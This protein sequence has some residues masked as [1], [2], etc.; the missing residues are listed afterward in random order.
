MTETTSDLLL[1][2]VD[3]VPLGNPRRGKYALIT[4]Q[5][6][7]PSVVPMF[8]FLTERLVEPEATYVL[9]K[10]YSTIDGVTKTLE[11]RGIRVIPN[12]ERYTRGQYLTD[13]A[14][15]VNSLW[16]CFLRNNDPDSFE[17]ILIIDEGGYLAGSVPKPI[18][19]KAVAIEQTASGS[20]VDK[21]SKVPVIQVA[22][23]AAKR[24][25]ES[26]FIGRSIWQRFIEENQTY[27]CS[28]GVIGLGTIGREVAIQAL[29]SGFQ[30]SGYD[31]NDTWIYENKRYH[32]ESSAADL[33]RNS[34]VIFGC[35][36]VDCFAGITLP[37]IDDF[38]K[39]II[40]GSSGDIEF[41][42][43][44]GDAQ[45]TSLDRLL[46]DVVAD[47]RPD[48]KI[49]NGGF[50]Y[51]FNRQSELESIS[52]IMLTRSLIIAGVAQAAKTTIESAIRIPLD[53]EVQRS[54]VRNWMENGNDDLEENL[55]W[56]I[57]HSE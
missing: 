29:N 33:M 22:L 49:L 16:D 52:D 27:N 40:S 25:F 28:V 57:H 35:T 5:H 11:A 24:V 37:P 31:I 54:I 44:L 23:S 14:E 20:F 1:H 19:H 43:L 9:G 8:D 41:R 38:T 13:I 45:R 32:L 26:P 2:L 12:R 53:A 55:Q 47:L 56:W 34:D 15:D 46:D 30:V 21:Q 7:L 18:C 6:L 3:Q 10:P 48:W 42:A 39:T 36:G 17:R 4:H 50:P 51:N